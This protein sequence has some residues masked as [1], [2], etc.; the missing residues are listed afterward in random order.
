MWRVA[1]I[2][3]VLVLGCSH[4]KA[5]DP[6]TASIQ[7]WEHANAE[8][9]STTPVAAN[10][11]RR[12]TVYDVR[13]ASRAAPDI[14]RDSFTYMSLPR[15]G[16]AKEDY[17]A[18]DGAEFAAQAQMTM[19]WTS[20]LY[21]ADVWVY[22]EIKQEP[23]LGSA[24]EVTIRPS[25]LH[26]QKEWVNDRTIRILVPYSA[27]GFRFS[28]E[29]KGQQLT[30]YKS[31][32]A[33]TTDAAGNPAVHTEP[34]NAMLIFAEP[35]LTGDDIDRLVP[36]PSRHAIYY[37]EEGRISNL[38]EITQEVIYF[39]PGT[40]FMDGT[41]HAHLRPEVRWVYL[42]P[43]AYVKGAFQFRSGS[44]EFKV[45]GFG[46]LSGEQYVYEADRSNAYKHRADTTPDCHSTCV[47][48]LEFGASG[49]PQQLTMH[50][51]TVANPPYNSFV[52]YG[53][54]QRF[55]AN[56]SQIKQVGGWYWQTDGPQLYQGSTVEHSF[57]HSNDD[58][59]KLYASRVKVDD[60]VVWK[61][62]NGPV[63]QW[64]WEPR[65]MNDVRVNNVDVIHNRMYL[66]SHNSC[67]LNSA[68]HYL[69]PHSRVL[70][71]PGQHISDLVLNN[72]RS[73]GKNLCAMR[74]FALSSWENI[75]IENLWIE[76]WNELDHETQASQFEA[77]SNAAG[78]RILIGNEVS[79]G[80][81][82]A[83][84]NYMVNGE[85]IDKSAENWSADQPGRLDFDPA[86]WESWDAR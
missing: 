66:D 24:D 16:R 27:Q 26:F 15:S 3:P 53:N 44:A 33:L 69:N 82:L 9:N 46:V 37:P 20:F 49:E 59:L 78:E 80:K 8:L 14:Y 11:V 5:A 54:V 17:N 71:D 85:R 36:N 50:G 35:M 68:R 23:A 38:D 64:G 42:A 40:Y 52:V 28:V 83:I 19:S 61:A 34:R 47:K 70:A 22:V 10:N 79:D 31:G 32:G 58:V 56:A 57:F 81:G 21:S 2:L 1:I 18:N 67:I 75:H 62:E 77:L 41:Y 25:T 29:F 39:R 63:I 76:E 60:I 30:S 86:L 48:M 45:T 6:Q 7:T 13:V 43:G 4:G 73:E 84:V 55:T 51:I 65:T 12:S 72:I 74:L